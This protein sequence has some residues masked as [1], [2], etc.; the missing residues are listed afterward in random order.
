MKKIAQVSWKSPSN[1]AFIK[2]WGKHGIQ[3]PMNPSLSMT[4]DK[5]FTQTSITLTEKQANSPIEFTFAFEGKSNSKFANRIE[6][7]IQQIANKL[8]FL[9]HYRLEIESENSFPHSA[10]IAS[11]A[12]AMSALALCLGTIEQ[13]LG[14]NMSGEFYQETSELARLGSGSA[15]RSLFSEFAVWGKTNDIKDSSDNYAVKLN[16]PIHPDLKCLRDVVLIVDA[17]EKKVSSSAGHGLMNNHPYATPRFLSAQQNLTTLL[18][19]MRSGDFEKFAEMLEHEALSLH[20]MMMTASPWYTLL[21]PN[22]LIIMEKIREFREESK[23]KIT[24]TLDAGPNV[25]VIFPADEDL[26]VKNFIEREL[27][28]YCSNRKFILD[29]IGSGPEIL[30]DEFT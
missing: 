11:S 23:V 17:E 9:D 19:A 22:S 21:S 16:V 30:I 5:C 4:L 18:A 15:S 24:F 2:Y 27:L 20:A 3:L 12:S 10:G 1:I 25:H 14:K 7:Y 13:R 26:K 29:S 28:T 8:S 6:K